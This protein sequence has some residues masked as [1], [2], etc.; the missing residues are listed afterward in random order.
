MR[1]DAEPWDVDADDTDAVDFLWKEA[2]RHARRGRHAQVGDHDH[3]VKLGICELVDRLA[4]ILEKLAGNKGF[5]I[6]GNVSDGA[7]RAVKMRGESQAVN[8]ARGSRKH[9]GGAAH[10]QADAQRAESRTHA[11]RLI[12]R[13]LRIILRVLFERLALA[14]SR[15]SLLH[16]GCA[17]MTPDALHPW[18]S[19][20]DWPVRLVSRRLDSRSTS[21]VV[22][23]DFAGSGLRGLAIK[24]CHKLT[25]P[26]RGVVD[27]FESRF[28][29]DLM[30]AHVSLRRR[31]ENDT[32]PHRISF[33]EAKEPIL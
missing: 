11:L 10:T 2:Q 13:P 5:G 15:G 1:G 17:C 16:L 30:A 9:R 29:N 4:D 31:L 28:L 20:R 19:Q 14:R 23:D 7:L 3:V 24:C 32:T 6:E 18:P 8:A 26:L 25:A 33:E 21:G 22:I 12:V 27:D